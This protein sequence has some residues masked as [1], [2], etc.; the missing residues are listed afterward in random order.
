[1]KRGATLLYGALVAIGGTALL[2]AMGVDA[3]A[4]VGR[5][6]G[7]PLLGSIEIVQAAVLVSGATALL[8][9]T[10]AGTHARVHLLVNRATPQMRTT[11]ERIGAVCG[12]ALFLAL[13][14]ASLWITA[15]LW[16]GQ[17]ESELLHLP[18]RPLRVFTVAATAAIAV[19]FLV[20]ALRGRR[21]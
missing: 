12:A 21:R 3:L 19:A 7:L 5:H 15:D 18:Y 6:A 16:S 9:A 2:V 11:L 1:M 4:V 10:L 17:E 20:E 8:V 13:L 14:A